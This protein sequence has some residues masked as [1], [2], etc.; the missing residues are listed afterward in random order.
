MYEQK[1]RRQKNSNEENYYVDIE[2]ERES[3]EIGRAV[4]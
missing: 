4:I 2:R 1:E 3:G